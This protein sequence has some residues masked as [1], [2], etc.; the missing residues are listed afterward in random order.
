MAFLPS[1]PVCLGQRARRSLGGWR[2]RGFTLLVWL[3]AGGV[4]ELGIEGLGRQ[5]EWVIL[6]R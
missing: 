3:K 2:W 5:R 4:T 1:G 6:P